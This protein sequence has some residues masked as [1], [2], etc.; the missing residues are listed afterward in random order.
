MPSNPIKVLLVDD[1]V[2]F[3]E[4]LK[5]G[6]SGY[7]DIQIGDSVG[8]VVAA[9]DSIL[10]NKPDAIVLDMEMP[11][12]R[13][14]DFLK[15]F[16]PRYPEIPVVVISSQPANVFEALSAGAVDFVSKPASARDGSGEFVN[17]LVGKIR[18]ARSMNKK[19]TSP[20]VSSLFSK[21]NAPRVFKNPK[22][23][24]AIGAST[25][26]TEAILAV[27]KDLP[28]N[29]PGIVIVQ[30]MPPVFTKMYAERLDK[31]CA[32][33]VKEAVNGDRV[34]PG[35]A[36]IAPGGEQHMRLMADSSG[37]FVRLSEGE[38]YSGHRPSVDVLFESTAK[39]AG[40]NAIGVILTGMGADGA[41]H[42]LTMRSAGAHTIGQDQASCI[43]YGM[44]MAAYN[45]GGVKEQLP[46]GGI[47]P[48]ILRQLTK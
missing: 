41:R 1:S 25:G 26:G 20:A 46:L 40:P 21:M 42:L 33:Q 32:M 5:R 30:H 31:Q 13:G 9:R 22:A 3:R 2:F 19:V 39:A 6:L 43:V 36:L 47:A 29:T 45:L 7:P 28:A 14:A 10:S 18:I 35:V 24:I 27:L 8:D 23:V 37:Y 11:I 48:A 44:P 12:M 4:M 16:H 15:Q 17:E 34:K 38:K